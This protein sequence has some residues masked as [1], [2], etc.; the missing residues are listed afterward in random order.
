L[1]EPPPSKGQFSGLLRRPARR[2]MI[3]QLFG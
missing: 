3:E 2:T 1:A